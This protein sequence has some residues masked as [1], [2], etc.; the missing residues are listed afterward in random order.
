MATTVVNMYKEKYDVYIGRVR[1]KGGM[2]LPNHFGNPF[3]IGRDGD[4]AEV[5][6]KFRRWINGDPTL[7]YVEP[8]RR[9]WIL[10]NLRTLKDK[11]LG[12]FCKP[13]DCHGDVYV[14]L[15]D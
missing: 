2:S 4:R 5:I 13:Q 12:C 1:T 11:K 15:L 3:I 14:E 8:D 6:D 7:A 9:R 10:D